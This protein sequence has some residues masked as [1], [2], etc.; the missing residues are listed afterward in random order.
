MRLQIG[1]MGSAADL[2]YSQ[3][4][5][6]IAEKV[7]ELV[8]KS[9]NVTV[10][11]AEKDYDSLSTAAAKG[12]KKAKGLTVGVTYGTGRNIYNKEDTD[13]TIVT[14]LGRGGGREFVLVNSCDAIIAISGGSGTLTELAQAYQLDIPMV[15]IEGTGGWSDKLANSFFDERKRRKV[16]GVKTAEEA[17]ALA[18][19]LAEEKL[20]KEGNNCEDISK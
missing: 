8:A 18:I 5:E 15:I 13:V 12:A 16:I 14:G 2:N 6:K 17:V 11:G 19:R 9:G 10:Y 20:N 4:I 3:Q 1:V 7:G